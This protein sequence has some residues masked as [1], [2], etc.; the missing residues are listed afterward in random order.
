M[1]TV[2]IITY[3]V[4][5]LAI[6]GLLI[7]FYFAALRQSKS[8]TSNR[9]YLLIT[10]MASFAIP[11]IENPIND[12]P[13]TIGVIETTIN[14]PI[15]D[16]LIRDQ[17]IITENSHKPV[18]KNTN[19]DYWLAIQWCYLG[20]L[21]FF[22]LRSSVNLFFFRRIKMES[23]LINKHW[24]SL[25]RTNIHQ[26][27]SFLKNVFIPKSIFGTSAYEPI[28]AHEC[29]HVRNWH[30]A[31]RLL[32]DFLV[33]LFWFNPFVYLYRNALI[34]V[35]EFQADEA[36][37]QQFGNP[38]GYQ[39]MLYEQLQPVRNSTLVSHFNY[40]TV[41]KRI[42]MMNKK[43]N[44]GYSRLMYVLT[45]PLLALVLV[46]FSSKEGKET[47]S[48][49]S[50][51]IGVLT[52]DPYSGLPAT[53]LFQ[54]DGLRPSILPLKTTTNFRV[55]STFGMRIDP[56]SKT[57]KM[58]LGID[59]ATPIGTEVLAA[60]NGEVLKVITASTG[61]GNHIIVAHGTEY[62]TKYAQL[63]QMQVKVG[64]KVS[65]GQVIALSGNSGQSKGPHLHYE[66]YK[67]EG[68]VDPAGYINNYDLEKNVLLEKTKEE[69]EELVKE[70]EEIEKKAGQLAH[71]AEFEIEKE[72]S[73]A[74]IE[75]EASKIRSESAELELERV[76]LIAENERMQSE[77]VKIQADHAMLE[78]ELAELQ[79]KMD[80]EVAK[81]AQ[82]EAL[83]N[84][85][86]DNGQTPLYILNG[87]VVSTIEDTDP[88]S[89]Q[90]VTVFK[91]KAAETE[92]GEKG[93]NGVVIITTKKKQ[94]GN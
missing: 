56:Y 61:Y 88:N 59:L 72:V 39:E 17:A 89:I 70:V 45:M 71:I 23:E 7:A 8:Y 22:V 62:Q 32:V 37:L 21:G 38:I 64:E 26:P 13:E 90:K 24:F 73:L 28:L 58:H 15:N 82:K 92:Y 41:K 27:F 49:F 20:V 5:I 12:A 40:S 94:K 55:T 91:G 86:Q 53:F 46:A 87:K 34:E 1:A 6:Q 11:F 33:S 18:S 81:K 85:K 80:M 51:S 42:V 19:F 57:K 35:H 47:I 69:V 9:W 79:S 14:Q 25:F 10:L 66:V 16:W 75:A 63:S 43:K 83:M 84:W 3:L 74:R 60:A 78:A 54:D 50:T 68:A 77:H 67:N 29:A 30:S 76:A 65:Q 52:T 48:T 93:A 36:V 4:K 2:E 31:D 44:V